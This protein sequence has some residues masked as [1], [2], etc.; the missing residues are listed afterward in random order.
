MFS[1]SIIH[2]ALA[3]ADVTPAVASPLPIRIGLGLPRTSGGR[4]T[5]IKKSRYENSHAS[6][7]FRP[8]VSASERLRHWVTPHALS[9]RNLMSQ[10][11]PSAASILMEVMLSSLEPKTRSNYGA[12]LLRFNQFC[13]RLGITEHDRCPAS[14]A[15]LSAFIASFAGKRSSDCIKGWLAGLK[16]WHTFQGAP[17]HGDLMLSSVK[18]G[19]AKLV[20]PESR[21]DKS[22]PVT[23]EHLHCLLR[24]LDLSNAKDAAIYAASSIAFHGVCR[25]VPSAVLLCVLS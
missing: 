7:I 13:D 5:K 20:P 10:I 6:S 14:E 15:L 23:I 8:H 24:N 11:P 18:K 22:E 2:Q 1:A 4:I 12:G 16:F 25:F 19:V 3:C 9:S 17:W 21:R